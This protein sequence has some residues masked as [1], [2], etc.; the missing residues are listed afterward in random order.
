VTHIAGIF[1][2]F[3]V[4]GQGGAKTVV[5]KDKRSRHTKKGPE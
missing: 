3:S 2:Y 4:S 1:S 5:I